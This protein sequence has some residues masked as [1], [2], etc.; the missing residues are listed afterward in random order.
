MPCSKLR[1]DCSWKR[2]Y[3]LERTPRRKRARPAT[4]RRLPSNAVLVR[5]DGIFC[6]RWVGQ[7]DGRGKGVAELEKLVTERLRKYI[8]DPVVTVSVQEIKGNKG[9]VIGQV[10]K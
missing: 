2:P 6:F 7:V 3:S 8:S 9:Y 1:S 4:A 10:T 5:L